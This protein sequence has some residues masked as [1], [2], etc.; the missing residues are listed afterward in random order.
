[1]LVLG[2]GINALYPNVGKWF[3]DDCFTNRRLICQRP[4]DPNATP[5]PPP[6]PISGGCP[7]QGNIRD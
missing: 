3:K 2:T 6:V 4:N 5:A 1:M 7:L